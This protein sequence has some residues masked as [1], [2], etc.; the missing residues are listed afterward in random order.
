MN[1]DFI[2][3][4]EARGKNS[5]CELIVPMPNEKFE[6]YLENVEFLKNGFDINLYNYRF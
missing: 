1:L 5:T 2:K 4:L 3:Q 6:T